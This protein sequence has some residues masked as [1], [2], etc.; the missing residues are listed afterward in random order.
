MGIIRTRARRREMLEFSLNITSLMDVLTVLLF[1]LLKSFSVTASAMTIP[2]ELH[3]P[4][5]EVKAKLAETVTLILTNDGIKANGLT[6]VKLNQGRFLA[7]D[8]GPD[9]RTLVTVKAFLDDQMTKRNAIFKGQVDP[10]QLPPGRVMIQA[11]KEVP[12][13][14]MKYLLYT[15][16]TSGYSDYEF[17]VTN[18]DDS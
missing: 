18:P 15:A 2:P 17:I 7:S 8:V 6:L 4:M 3:L 9:T 16:S 5:S 13:A 14:T 11:D 1:F 10:K 12:F